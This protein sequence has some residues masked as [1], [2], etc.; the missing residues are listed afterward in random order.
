MELLAF[1]SVAGKYFQVIDCLSVIPIVQSLKRLQ[2]KH[3][4]T[5]PCGGKMNVPDTA[6]GAGSYQTGG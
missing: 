2:S 1:W 5:T 3:G 4:I 6:E